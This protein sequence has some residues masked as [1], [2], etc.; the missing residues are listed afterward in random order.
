MKDDRIF[1]DSTEF[2]QN[3]MD[4]IAS[5]EFNKMI[6]ATVFKD[7]DDCKRAVAHGMAIAVNIYLM[8]K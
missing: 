8:V 6:D 4:Y 1:I 7:S 3:V 2:Q 5:D